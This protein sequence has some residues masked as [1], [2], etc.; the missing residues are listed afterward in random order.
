MS[1]N[2]KFWD[3]KNGKILSHTIHEHNN[4]LGIIANCKS[5]IT[6]LLKNDRIIFLGSDTEE[7]FMKSIIGIEEGRV[8]CREAVDYC[9]TKFKEQ[10]DE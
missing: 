1:E 2:K 3:T 9:Y 7:T 5:V 4:G 10:E 8:R 6:T